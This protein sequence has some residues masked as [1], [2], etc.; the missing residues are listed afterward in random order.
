MKLNRR[1]DAAFNGHPYAKS[2]IDIACWEILGQAV[3][4][5]VCELLGGRYGSN[6]H[7]DRAISQESPPA[8][9]FKGFDQLRRIY[10][11]RCN[12]AGT[13]LSTGG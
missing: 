11:V 5:P 9:T 2:G 7:L 6:V 3:G 10:A 1:M 13:R 12:Q 8:R 4:V